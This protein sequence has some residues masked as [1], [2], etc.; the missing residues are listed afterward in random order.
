MSFK[1]CNL[2]DCSL[3]WYASRFSPSVSLEFGATTHVSGNFLSPLFHCFAALLLLSSFHT[4]D[5]EEVYDVER[6]LDHH[7]DPT[8]GITHYLVKWK[9]YD[10]PA[11]EP[12]HN[13]LD[14]SLIANY[15]KYRD[16]FP[17]RRARNW[18][19][20]DPSSESSAHS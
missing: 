4:S 13:I 6:L 18:I 1:R 11:W 8:T 16:K 12:Q 20:F 5:K 10:T 14:N 15:H 9:G 17:H 3:T 2:Y 7:K 19:P